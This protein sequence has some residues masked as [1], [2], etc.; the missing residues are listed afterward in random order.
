MVVLCT[1]GVTEAVEY[2]TGEPQFDDM[3]VMVIKGV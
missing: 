3:T 2:A 1:D